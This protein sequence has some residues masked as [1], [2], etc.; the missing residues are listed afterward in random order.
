MKLSMNSSPLKDKRLKVKTPQLKENE[1]IEEI[2]KF[3]KRKKSWRE[4]GE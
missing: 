1:R 4:I 2:S 3:E